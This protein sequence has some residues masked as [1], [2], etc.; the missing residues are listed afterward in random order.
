MAGEET[1]FK[2]L[3]KAIGEEKLSEE[4]VGL[5]MGFFPNFVWAFL[6]EIAFGPGLKLFRSIEM[7]L[8]RELV[9][10]DFEGQLSMGFSM[11][12]SWGVG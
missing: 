3:G 4:K 11:E 6:L 5:A 8:G 10:R 12:V 9:G 1:G 7:E 2:R